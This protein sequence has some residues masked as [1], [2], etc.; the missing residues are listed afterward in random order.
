MREPARDHAAAAR[1]RLIIARTQSPTQ[2][3]I[4][5]VLR[6]LLKG[7]EYDALDRKLEKWRA[8]KHASGETCKVPA[9][10]RRARSKR[11]EAR[12]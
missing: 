1:E 5:A 8:S 2:K 3:A 9:A 12:P 6:R 10:P 11:E 4:I 7:A